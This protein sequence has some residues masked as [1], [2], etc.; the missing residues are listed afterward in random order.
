M[1]NTNK[2]IPDSSSNFY[3]GR[4]ILRLLVFIWFIFN[5]L[6]ALGQKGPAPHYLRRYDYVPQQTAYAFDSVLQ[7]EIIFDRNGRPVEQKYF[8]QGRLYNSA[9]RTYDHR[10]RLVAL[11]MRDSAGKAYRYYA[12]QFDRQGHLITD[13]EGENPDSLKPVRSYTYQGDFL[14]RIAELNGPA[15]YDRQWVRDSAGN[16]LREEVYDGARKTTKTLATYRWDSLGH[17][18]MRISVKEYDAWTEQICKDANCQQF[19]Q[20]KSYVNHGN[21]LR[22]QRDLDQYGHDSL[23]QFW[24]YNGR[25]QQSHGMEYDRFRTLLRQWNPLDTLEQPKVIAWREY[26]PQGHLIHEIEYNVRGQKSNE[27]RWQYD[28]KGRCAAEHVSYRHKVYFYDSLDRIAFRKESADFDTIR[29]AYRYDRYD[30]LEAISPIGKIS[31]RM[32]QQSMLGETFETDVLG[33][34]VTRTHRLLSSP[35]GEW[36]RLK[37]YYDGR[38]MLECIYPNVCWRYQYDAQNRLQE[39]GLF[40]ENERSER[41]RYAYDQQ[42]RLVTILKHTGN[43]QTLQCIDYSYPTSTTCVLTQRPELK[44]KTEYRIT[45][46]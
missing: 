38:L 23:V 26:D 32:M 34:S 39:A 16:P 37:S 14:I 1:G 31:P 33:R 20:I 13:L 9:L 46:W 44:R 45:Y 15:P 8:Q 43:Q 17:F 7:E 11:V 12:S 18:W 35:Q 5:V 42:G 29:Y 27:V 2:L 21:W 3:F 25:L 28:L 22:E 36:H 19:A 40:Y 6:L 10:D 4:G 30:S 24:D 41:K